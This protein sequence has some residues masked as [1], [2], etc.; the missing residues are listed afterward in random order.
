MSRT[1]LASSFAS[2]LFSDLIP[3]P[4]GASD[5]LALLRLGKIPP[6]E[7]IRAPELPWI[8]AS[9]SEFVPVINVISRARLHC[10]T[11]DALAAYSPEPNVFAHRSLDVDYRPA[12]RARLERIR[13]L[14]SDPCYPLVLAA[15]VYRFSAS[16]SLPVILSQPWMTEPLA[17]ELSAL[18][19]TAGRCLL[20]GHH[21]ANRIASA[22]LANVDLTLTSVVGHRWVRWSDDIHVFVADANEAQSIR[23][24]LSEELSGVGL[25]LSQEKTKLLSIPEVLSGVARDVSGEPASVWHSGIVND[26]VRALRYA[27]PRLAAL[28]DPVA[29]DDLLRITRIHPYVIPRALSYLDHLMEDLRGSEVAVEMLKREENALFIGR[30]LSL[31]IRHA[32]L[33]A[34]AVPDRVLH[35]AESTGVSS[36]QGLAW[37]VALALGKIPPPPDRR[38]AGWVSQGAQSSEQLPSL[39]TTL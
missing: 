38:L 20:P 37:R 12:Y 11:A 28:R 35:I 34:A 33:L 5:V 1:A 6:A 39:E 18:N 2:D 30:L 14:A 21:W 16:V 29:L 3:D 24:A 22:V 26:D 7:P 13:N 32:D 23:R 19:A 10:L 36:L 15:D 9:R 31:A 8:M 4:I 27:L 17:N 25:E